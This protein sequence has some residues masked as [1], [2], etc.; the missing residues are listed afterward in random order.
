MSIIQWLFFEATKFSLDCYT[1]IMT[2]PHPVGK[3]FLQI[4]AVLQFCP[5][6]QSFFSLIAGC[7]LARPDIHCSTKTIASVLWLCEQILLLCVTHTDPG[8]FQILLHSARYVLIR[9]GEER[10]L[11]LAQVVYP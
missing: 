5:I 10:M 6:L 11:D 3:P 2:G 7:P 9:S 8:P 4:P 1:V